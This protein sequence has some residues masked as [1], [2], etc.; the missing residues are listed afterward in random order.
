MKELYFDNAATTLVDPRVKQ[1]MDKYF[2]EEY[3]NPGSFNTVGLRALKVL[4]ESRAT[5]A[6]CINANPNE[7]IFTGS[8]TESINLAIQGVA[9]A[10]KQKGK[11]IIISNIEHHAVLETCE[12]LRKDEGYDITI[13]QPDQYGIISPQSVEKAIRPDTILISIMFANNEIGTIN[14]IK[15]IGEIARKNR[16]YFHT[17]A[18]QAGGACKL[19]VKQLNVDLLTLNGSKIYAP[20]G[21]GILYIRQG[22]MIKPIIYGGG[23]ERNLRSGTENVPYIVGFAKAMEL[24]EQEREKDNASISK[25]RDKLIKGVMESIPL[26]ILNGHPTERLPNNVNI[27]FLNIEGE[28]LLLYMN[29]HGICA[30]SGS[31][32]T[33][34]TLDPSHVIIGIGRPYEVAHGSIRFSLGKLTT[35]EDIDVLLKVLPSLVQ[36][37]REISPVNLT[38]EQVTPQ[39]EGEN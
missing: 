26:S 17:D 22:V 14:P 31:A 39:I 37:L 6:R 34:K 4:D 7:V 10:M 19:D 23:Q 38:L 32:C 25:L 21:V 16:V 30:S 12:Y 13:L 24:A 29:E 28:A 27:T 2:S 33:S 3:G 35:E 8:G 18:C 20:K 1:E 5:V 15:Q 11:H 9:K 36:K